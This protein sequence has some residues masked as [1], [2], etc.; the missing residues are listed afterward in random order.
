M[1]KGFS[2]LILLVVIVLLP[3]FANAQFGGEIDDVN[4]V[5]IDGGL[6]ILLAAGIGYG[7]NKVRKSKC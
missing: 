7:A 2:V 6:S 5:P 1:K 4:D 3:T